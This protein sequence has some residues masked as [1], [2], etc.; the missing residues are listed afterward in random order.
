MRDLRSSAAYRIAFTYSAAFAL[1]IILLGVAVYFAADAD[2]RRQQDEN[3][4]AESAELVREYREEGIGD[5]RRAIAAREGAGKAHAFEYALFDRSGRRVAGALVTPRPPRGWNTLDFM[6]PVEG[7]DPARALASV[8]PDGEML[9]VAIDSEALERIDGTILVLFSAALVLMLVVSGVGALLLGGYLRNRIERISGTARAIAGGNLDRRVAVS[10]RGDEFDRLGQSLNAML[11]RIAR[12]LDNLRQVSSDV[13]HDLRTP[14]ARLRGELEMALIAAPDPARQHAALE[15]AL[16]QSDE[17]LALF[18][19]ILR[20]AEVEGGALARAFAPLD[21]GALVSDLG[22]SYAPAIADS[23]RRMTCAIAESIAVHGDR[24]LI[25]QALI[26]L[27]DNTQRHTPPGTTI[28]LSL[29]LDRHHARIAVADNGAGVSPEDRGRIAQR[30]VRLEN[31]RT[32]QGHGLG[33]NL[34]NAI[35]LAHGGDLRFEDN[36]PGLRAVLTLPILRR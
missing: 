23:G 14:L 33:L 34:V 19:A 5:L 2:F 7:P 4:A 24:E 8:L 6:D 29:E 13:A 18:A 35:A 22:E 20:I 15:S 32:T 10:L 12:L 11:D 17:M 3:I 21:L 28:S 25:S 30:F 9:V 1:A 16:R 31:S 36:A 27:L 26:N